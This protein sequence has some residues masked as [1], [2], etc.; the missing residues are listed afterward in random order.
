LLLGHTPL[1]ER[2]GGRFF[3]RERFE[4]ERLLKRL[5]EI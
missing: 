2:R 4:I 1:I 3:V 5:G